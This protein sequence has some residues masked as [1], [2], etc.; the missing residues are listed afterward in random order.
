MHV[1]SNK[2]TSIHF[3][4]RNLR[5]EKICHSIKD[6][7]FYGIELDDTSSIGVSLKLQFGLVAKI[8]TAI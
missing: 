5:R 3:L 8:K 1:A 4:R 7:T 2:S 6:L